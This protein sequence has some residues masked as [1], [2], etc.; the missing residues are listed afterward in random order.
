MQM[1]AMEFRWY[2][3]RRATILVPM[4]RQVSGDI[5]SW[6][7]RYRQGGLGMPPGS[8][9]IGGR[10]RPGSSEACWGNTCA[11]R[12]IASAQQAWIHGG[13]P[14]PVNGLCCAVH[15]GPPRYGADGSMC[16]GC[17]RSGNAPTFLCGAC[18]TSR[19]LSTTV[20]AVGGSARSCLQAPP[21]P[22][23]TQYPRP[24][25]IPLALPSQC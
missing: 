15:S 7:R 16:P 12:D 17:S 22:W 1:S 11:P 18:T 10:P 14:V 19:L 13:N 24:A 25:S 21:R 9:K 5:H 8:Q 20:C 6:Q 4:R 2:L 23:L 3:F